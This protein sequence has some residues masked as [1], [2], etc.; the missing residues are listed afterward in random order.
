MA[1]RY[2]P[3]VV[4]GLAWLGLA[5]QAS[6]VV[7]VQTSDPGFYNNQIGTVLNG[8]NGG[9]TGPFPVSNDS[10]LDFG[11]EPDL[12]AAGAALGNWLTDPLHLNANWSFLSSIPNSW[13]VGTEVA[14]IYQFDTLEATN[15]VARFGVDNRIFVWLDGA[16]IGGARRGGGVSLG[17]H[18][19]ALGDLTAGT[20]F[21]QLLLEDHGTTNGYA[22]EITA[23]T[24]T[25][26]PPPVPE[27]FAVALRAAGGLALAGRASRRS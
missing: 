27:P 21:L 7:L 15:V 5:V 20:H 26:G 6:A 25:P 19:F 24:F 12:S 2:A 8:T 11:S 14:V 13:Q 18:T 22:V 4:L 10:N 9:E 16:Y 23:D 17:E 3:A 1:K